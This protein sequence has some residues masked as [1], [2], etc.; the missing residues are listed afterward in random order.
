MSGHE[1]IWNGVSSSTIPEFV[2]GPITR[3]LLGSHRGSFV[4]IPGRAGSW[5][6]AEQRGRRKVTLECF[7]LTDGAFS[8]RR[9]AITAVAEWLDVQGE[10]QLILGDEPTVFYNA[11]LMTPPDPAEWRQ[12]GVFTLEFSV[13]PYSYALNPTT[14]NFNPTSGVTHNHDFDLEV[15][16]TPVID[17]SPTNGTSITGFTLTVGTRTLS[18]AA[19]LGVGDTV[20]I[21][22]RGLAVL[23]GVNDDVNVTGT[24]DPAVRLMT[25]V[26]GQFPILLP[27]SNAITFTKLGGDS[28]TFDIDIYYRKQ[29]RK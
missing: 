2:C 10:A 7:V 6:F 9:D 26:T 21:N 23:A 12:I 19:P 27:G 1:V 16:S 18:Y 13:E 24:Y 25:A 5:Y 22:G 29:Y 15:M 28:T 3:A 14:Y 20:S 8:A 17:I 11:V 4:E